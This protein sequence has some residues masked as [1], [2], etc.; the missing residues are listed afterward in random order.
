MLKKIFKKH[1]G[2]IS[3][4]MGEEPENPIELKPWEQKSTTMKS[5]SPR[6][7]L[8]PLSPKASPKVEA[9]PQPSGVTAEHFKEQLKHILSLIENHSEAIV[10]QRET[11]TKIM[12]RIQ[13]LE[14]KNSPMKRGESFLKNQTSMLAGTELPSVLSMTNNANNV[15]SML[16]DI[17]SNEASYIRPLPNSMEPRDFQ[18]IG[19]MRGTPHQRRLVSL[20][21]NTTET[22]KG[23]I[24]EID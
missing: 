10:L 8:T 24:S 12:V 19:S 14:M 15:S 7:P 6:S 23:L 5:K 9:Q 4:L 11:S 20:V 2:K 1:E 21:A 13:M 16:K 22:D 3:T 18:A 17:E